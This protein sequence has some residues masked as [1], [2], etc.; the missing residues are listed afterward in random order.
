MP[1]WTPM[2]APVRE[3]VQQSREEAKG[4]AAMR[5]LRRSDSF[6]PALVSSQPG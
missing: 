1:G 2:H 4:L 3:E 5:K 6:R